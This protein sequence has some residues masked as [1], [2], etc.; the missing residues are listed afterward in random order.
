VQV[1]ASAGAGL[2]AAE[3]GLAQ[4]VDP[5]VTMACFSLRPR[6]TAA[7][8][9]RDGVGGCARR[10]LEHDRDGRR[11][12]ERAMCGDRRGGRR[13]RRRQHPDHEIGPLKI[14]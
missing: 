6:A 10:R 4:V 5:P 8:G 11:R 12:G 7:G 9:R 13:S 1:R 14:L 3:E 2:D